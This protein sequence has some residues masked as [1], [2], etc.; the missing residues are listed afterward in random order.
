MSDVTNTVDAYVAMW[1]ETNP[2][3]RAEA[4]RT[5]WTTEGHYVDPLMESQGYDGLR[6]RKSVV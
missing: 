6:D 3:K 4:I 2:T 5:A 1:N